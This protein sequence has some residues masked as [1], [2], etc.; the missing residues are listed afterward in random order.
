MADSQPGATPTLMPTSQGTGRPF[1]RHSPKHLRCVLVWWA[2]RTSD[3]WTMIS[4]L[5]VLSDVE[6]ASAEMGGIIQEHRGKLCIQTPT[7][8]SLGKIGPAED[9]NKRSK[10]WMNSIYRKEQRLSNSDAE[11][12]EEPGKEKGRK[13]SPVPHWRFGESGPYL[14]PFTKETILI[15]RSTSLFPPNWNNKG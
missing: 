9:P 11:P 8:A 12:G 5:P 1:S 6:K 15:L 13:L 7:I 14:P 4:F 2:G 10:L 3:R